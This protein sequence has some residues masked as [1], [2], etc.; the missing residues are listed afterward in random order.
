MHS[1]NAVPPDFAITWAKEAEEIKKILAE[2]E[3]AMRMPDAYDSYPEDYDLA[4]LSNPTNSSAGLSYTR[5][6]DAVE[7]SLRFQYGKGYEA[8][9]GMITVYS[10]CYR[11][12]DFFGGYGYW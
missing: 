7:C 11:Q 8:T 5:H 3:W 10:Q 4:K 1:N 2:D 9:H 6:F 12:I